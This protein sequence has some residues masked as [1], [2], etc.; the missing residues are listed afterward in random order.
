MEKVFFFFYKILGYLIYPFVLIVIQKRLK[1]GKED[2][3][4]YQERYGIP[5]F[6]KNEQEVVWL[7]GES[8]GEVLSLL[9]LIH[10]WQKKNPDDL[11]LI[12]TMTKTGGDMIKSKMPDGCVHQFIPMDIY[13]WCKH[14]LD[15]W[16]PKVYILAESGIWP[17]LI[18][19]CKKR[20]IK[21]KLISAKLSLNS[22]TLWKRF[23]FFSKHF[24]K[25][26]DCVLAQTEEHQKRYLNLG[27]KN[28]L[29]MPTLKYLND[30]LKYDEEIYN[31]LKEQCNNRLVFCAVSTH[32][33]EENLFVKTYKSLRQK[34]PNLL[35]ILIPRH[36]D[37]IE[38]IVQ[39]IQKC[40]ATINIE[41]RSESSSIHASIN[42]Y[43][44]DTFGEVGLFCK[45]SNIV[46]LGGT[47]VNI[48]GHNPL[49]PL[50]LGSR[51]IVGPYHQNIKDLVLDLKDC[52]TLVEK[53]QDLELSIHTMLTEPSTSL[54]FEDHTK[55][56]I[57]EKQNTLNTIIEKYIV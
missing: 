23:H 32:K 43:I 12:T 51:L 9:P 41:R 26:F 47:F 19:L 39:D 21:I 8:I 44:V 14:F 16:N 5:S 53:D 6:K 56:I 18:S 20:N 34:H 55:N 57:A 36:I 22:Y 45:L 2:K 50:M 28:V 48:G 29:T 46:I 7:H 27:A 25:L 37:R 13:P 10:Y 17:N 30:P 24:F 4:H 52:I 38:N 31:N 33:G 54:T 11:I 15:Y 3:N 35:L 40:D 49:E 1:K 42:I